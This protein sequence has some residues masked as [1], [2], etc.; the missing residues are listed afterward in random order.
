M[1]TAKKIN[2]WTTTKWYGNLIIKE[3][4]IWI[5]FK[6]FKWISSL[7]EF[8]NKYDLKNWNIDWKYISVYQKLQKIQISLDNIYKRNWSC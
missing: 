6:N 4:P 2:N 1:I 3:L 8:K 5:D 7:K